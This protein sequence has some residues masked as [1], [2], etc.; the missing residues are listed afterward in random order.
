MAHDL[1]TA[2]AVDARPNSVAHYDPADA[3]AAEV[4]DDAL[5]RPPRVIHQDLAF[6]AGQ[7]ARVTDLATRLGV[8]RT[9][10]QVHLDLVAF[11]HL[12]D[13]QAVASKR[14]HGA[15]VLRPVVPGELR[16]WERTEVGPAAGRGAAR[17][18]PLLGHGCPEAV[19]V[20]I[21]R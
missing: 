10:V 20:Q 5:E 7:A 12:R 6:G 19:G 13:L 17:A 11:A 3:S 21:G 18:L 1:A 14:Q 15:L 8:E 4:S 2:R 9:P 16:R